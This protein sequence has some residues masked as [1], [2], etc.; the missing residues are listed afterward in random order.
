MISR[1]DESSRTRFAS[2]T[3]DSFGMS[4]AKRRAFLA[5]VLIAHGIALALLA[6]SRDDVDPTP[7]PSF[8]V[9]VLPVGESMPAPKPEAATAPEHPSRRASRVPLP[10]RNAAAPRGVLRAPRTDPTGAAQGDNLEPRSAPDP[11][12]DPVAVMT[13]STPESE[14]P[15]PATNA[16]VDMDYLSNP[17]PEYPRRSRALREQG[18][19]SLRVHVSE[20]GVPDAIELDRSSGY[21]RLDDAAIAAVWRWR[22]APARQDGREIAGWAIV[23]I[24]FALR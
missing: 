3:A 14:A 24:R 19:V 4:S 6:H 8:M 17:P 10:A 22:F 11:A 21:R 23:P 12:P 1:P 18:L 2:A 20:A 13:S 7:P 16:I 5:T 15:A 9:G